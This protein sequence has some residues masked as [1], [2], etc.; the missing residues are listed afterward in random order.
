MKRMSAITADRLKFRTCVRGEKRQN[1]KTT[2]KTEPYGFKKEFRS[3]MRK[4]WSLYLMALPVLAFY[5]IFCYKPMYGAIIAFKQYTPGLG[6]WKSPWV[7]LDNFRYFFS[8]PDFIRILSNTLRISLS[9][10][11]FGF[12]APIILTLL[13][14]EIGNKQFK[15]VAQSVSYIPHFISLVVICGLIKTFV[16]DGSI[17]QQIVHAFDGRDGSLLNRAEMFLPIYVISNIWQNIGWDSIIY[18]AAISSIDPQ[19]YEAAQVDGAGKWK[20]MLHVTLPGL[21]PT[22]IIMLILQ[23]G[24]ILSVGYEKIIL[25]YNPLIYD[26]SDVILSYVYRMGFESMDWSYSTAVGLFNS[27]VNFVI[28]ILANTIS[29]KV[30]DTS[31]W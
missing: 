25:L 1:M 18:L 14:N 19:L 6:I 21:A 7:G 15:R 9:L 27:V 11:I 30:S 8:N 20:R 12:P 5:M 31:L 3:N 2:K 13:F 26:T 28:I 22:I 10:I 4:N 24:N 29:R 16:A 17:I 23:L